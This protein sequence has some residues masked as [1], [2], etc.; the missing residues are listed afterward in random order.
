MEE[1][2]K[3]LII[4]DER[5]LIKVLTERF[6]GEGFT[7]FNATNGKEGLEVAEQNQPDIILLDI[8]M[9]RM[10]GMTM[11][12]Q[13]REKPWGKDIPV[14]ILTNLGDSEKVAEAAERGVYDF[15]VKTNWSLDEIV[16]KVKERLNI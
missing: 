16:A 11:L 15:L 10:D 14:V 12:K 7:V 6:E 2:K 3:I 5:D 9:P 4:E 8:I 13:L 1:N